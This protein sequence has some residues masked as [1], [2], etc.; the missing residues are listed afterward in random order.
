MTPACVFPIEVELGINLDPYRYESRD[1]PPVSPDQ[2]HNIDKPEENLLLPS[3]ATP[4]DEM[5]PPHPPTS[6]DDLLS[7]PQ[8][9][10]P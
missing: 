9:S 7:L 3:L 6:I 2:S 8:S 10:E 1:L 5:K 4:T